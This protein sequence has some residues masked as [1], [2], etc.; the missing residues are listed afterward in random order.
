MASTCIRNL[1]I[2]D[3][4]NYGNP[5]RLYVNKNDVRDLGC[6]QGFGGNSRRSPL[7]GKSNFGKLFSPYERPFQNIITCGR[8]FWVC[9]PPPPPLQKL[10]PVFM[11]RCPALLLCRVRTYLV[12]K[13]YSCWCM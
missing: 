8:P 5:L 9:P 3:Y 12:K 1:I 6:P 2:N 4:R 11:Y 7:P 10:M 13:Y